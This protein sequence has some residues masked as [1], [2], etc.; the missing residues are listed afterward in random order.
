MKRLQ[1]GILLAIGVV[2][3][4]S[5]TPAYA[6]TP[7]PDSDP[8][9]NS[10]KVYRNLREDGDRLFVIYSNIPYADPPGDPITETFI[11]ELIDT[12]GVTV[13]GSTVGYAYVNSG[14][15]YNVCSLYFP[16]ADAL[17]WTPDP[18]YTVRLK[19]NPMAGF[20]DLPVYNYTVTDEDYTLFSLPDDVRTELAANIV[21][22]AMDLDVQWGLGDTSL[23]TAD[24]TGVTLSIFG[25]SFFR[26][27]IYGI[28]ALAPALFPLGITNIALEDR[29]WDEAYAGELEEQYS[30]TWVETARTAG[31]GLFG[32]DFDLLTLI[33]LLVA[34]IGVV[35]ANIY[36]TNDHWNGLIDAAF[37][38]IVAAKLGFYGLGYLGLIA[39]ICIIYIGARVWG[40]ARG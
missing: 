19:G 14:Y 2:L 13:L 10:K 9:V 38:M 28:Q 6:V 21:V 26:G 18:P 25:Q 4:L 12:D 31:A 1:I 16:A 35:V 30:G 3:L 40:F 39:A 5:A 23:I 24:E 34:F 27:A 22:I 8:I 15:G 33:I 36:L 29:E 37:I 32:V 20:A 7:P 11:W 17:A